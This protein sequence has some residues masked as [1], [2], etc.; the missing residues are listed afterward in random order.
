MEIDYLFESEKYKP[1]HISVLLVGEAPPPSKKRYFYLPRDLSNNQPV[2]EDTSLSA[3]IFNHYFK[4][5]PSTRKE[6]QQFLLKL[7]QRG[8]FLID[9]C[10]DPIRVR[11][12]PE[13]V[14]RIIDEI[15]NLRDKIYQ[16]AIKISDEDIIFLLPRPSY[17]KHLR[18]YFPDSKFVRWKDFRLSG[19]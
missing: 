6:Y 12:C 16:R 3:T 5:R 9:I 8:I 7:K 2:E 11:N 10:D 13:G 14:Q 15:P 1:N 18:R 19:V 17:K 4:K